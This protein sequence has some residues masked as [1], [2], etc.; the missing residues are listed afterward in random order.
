[1]G[2]WHG[3]PPTHAALPALTAAGVRH[4]FT[5]RHQ[6][7]FDPVSAS[8]GPFGQDRRWPAFVAL[9]VEPRTVRYARQVHGDVCLD[10]DLQGTGGLVGTGDALITRA[11]A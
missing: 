10:A 9:G 8:A 1:M 7:S 6:G 5:T 11:R 4:A 2:S 3:D